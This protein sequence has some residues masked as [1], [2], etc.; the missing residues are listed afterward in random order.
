[1]HIKF[2]ESGGFAGLS[3]NFVLDD[4][5]LDEDKKAELGKLSQAALS[6]LPNNSDKPSGNDMIQYDIDIDGKSVSANDGSMTSPLR[7]LY[8]FVKEQVMALKK[9]KKA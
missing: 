7:D 2:S 9:A 1:M 8:A 3:K 6:A 5:D 4:K